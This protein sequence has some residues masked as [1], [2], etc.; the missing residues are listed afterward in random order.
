MTLQP[1]HLTYKQIFNNGAYYTPLLYVEKVWEFIKPYIKNNSVILDPACGTGNFFYNKETLK[2]KLI[3]NDIDKKAIELVNMNFPF[4]KTYNTNALKDVN[5]KKYEIKDSEYLIIIGNPPYN[6]ITSQNKKKQKKEIVE[7]D[8]DIKKRD[9]GISFLLSYEK[10]NADI[11]CVLHP[12]SYLI[13]KANFTSLKRFTAKYRLKDSLIIDSATFYKNSKNSFPIIIGLYIKDKEGM[14]YDYIFNYEFKTIDG[15]TFK[16]SNYEYIGN[17]I[18]KYPQTKKEI[19]ENSIFF[20]TMRDINALKRNKT[21]LG[22]NISNAIIVDPNKLEYYI[23]VDIFK[24]YI[25]KIPYYFGNLDIIIN[26]KLF[27]KYKKYFIH[28]GI[29]KY[30]NLKKYFKIRKLKDEKVKEKINEYFNKLLKGHV[31]MSLIVK[32]DY[33]LVPIPLTTHTGKIR[34]KERDNIYGYGNPTKTRTKPFNQKYYVEWQIGFDTRIPNSNIPYTFQN[35]KGEIK[36]LYELSEI[37]C[38]LVKMGLVSKNDIL[39][40]RNFISSLPTNNLIE[41]HPD[42]KIL[43]SHP[44]LEQINGLNFEMLRISYPQLIYKFG[45]YEVIAEITI[46]EKQRAVGIQPM[47]YICFPITLLVDKNGIP[48]NLIGRIAEKNE[49]AYFK[50]DS[51]NK[52]IILKSFEIFGMLAESHKTDVERILNTIIN[53]C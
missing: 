20:Y 49:I 27:A 26:S 19:N 3:G 21:F 5:R 42:C 25:D 48:L 39:Q 28:Y 53:Y 47:L 6:D 44:I 31:K 37:L 14:D 40:I 52:D 13:K 36:Y 45:I 38:Y 41:K 17:F 15:N 32:K 1:K 2:N 29:N 24:E 16:L 34:I 50:I 46:K 23:Y 22:K 51:T 35:Y 4:V 18:Q 7:I 12:L 8:D 43:R 33:I 10:L 9:L 11:I 30:P